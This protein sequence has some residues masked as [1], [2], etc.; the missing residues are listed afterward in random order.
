MFRNGQAQ[1]QQLLCIMYKMSEKNMQWKI[2]MDERISQL[3]TSRYVFFK[4]FCQFLCHCFILRNAISDFIS[5]VF[6][7]IFRI[8]IATTQKSVN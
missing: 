5:S 1:A 6:Q 4:D 2:K 8:A 3:P 7:H